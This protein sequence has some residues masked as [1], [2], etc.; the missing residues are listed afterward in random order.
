MERCVCR[1]FQG[2]LFLVIHPFILWKV[3]I[4][5]YIILSYFLERYKYLSIMMWFYWKRC[6]RILKWH[7]NCS[8][9]I[10][11]CYNLQAQVGIKDGN[12]LIVV[13]SWHTG[14][15]IFDLKLIILLNCL[16]I[17]FLWHGRYITFH[18]MLSL[19]FLSLPFHF[20]YVYSRLESLKQLKL[21]VLFWVKVVDVMQPYSHKHLFK[22]LMDTWLCWFVSISPKERERSKKIYIYIGRLKAL[23]DF[24]IL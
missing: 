3:V 13:E 14:G 10:R 5:F 19:S 16:S 12:I 15:T 21:L 4:I 22:H 24:Y 6:W 17:L 9:N 11:K 1:G 8:L 23:F 2:L 7:C 18:V 20:I